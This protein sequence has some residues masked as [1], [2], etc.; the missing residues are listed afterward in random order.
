MTT[1][2][3]PGPKKI[4]YKEKGM[5]SAVLGHIHAGAHVVLNQLPIVWK[6]IIVVVTTMSS[7]VPVDLLAAA[8]NPLYFGSLVTT[9]VE[10][11]STIALLS[12]NET[13]RDDVLGE[14][15]T[16]RRLWNLDWQ[17]FHEVCGL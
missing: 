4:R 13:F 3:R 17:A 1:S 5:D 12:F 8:T 16:A 2:S 15:A 10:D 6:V 14:N 9:N 11:P 7:I